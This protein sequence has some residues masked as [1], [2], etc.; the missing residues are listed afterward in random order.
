MAKLS[1]K[2]RLLKKQKELKDRSKGGK[3]LTIREGTTR[4]RHVPITDE[5]EFAVEVVYF[6]LNKELGGLISNA[7]FNE[8]CPIMEAYNKFSSSKKEDDRDF[9]KQFKPGKKFFSPVVKYK[10]EKGKE[11]DTEAGVKLLIITSGMY[12]ELIEYFL[13][14]DEGGDFTHPETGYDIKYS[15]TGKGKTDTEY[16]LRACKPTKLSKP[17]SKETYDPIQMVK[18]ITPSYDEAKEMLDKFLNVDIDD[19]EDDDDQPKKKKKNKDKKK[20]KKKDL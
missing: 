6:Y 4:M 19:L 15:R 20:K 5:K 3:F 18:D 13:D 9:A 8:K 2:E 12:Q 17:F 11:L 14:E 10:D 7:T 16:S 1:L